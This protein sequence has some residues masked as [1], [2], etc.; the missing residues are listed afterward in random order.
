VTTERLYYLDS[1]LTDFTAKVV[2]SSADGRR[3]Y[4]DR[5]AF[6]PSSGG[7][8]YDLGRLGG[9]EI[10]EV[11]D[12]GDRIA[13]ITESAV[14]AGA[15]SG[16]IHWPRRYDHMQQ[17]TG[18]HLLSAVL[19]EM[20][21]F[22]TL[23]FHLGDEVSTIEISTKEITEKQIEEAE[24]HSNELAREGRPVRIAFEDAQDVKGLR[25]PSER[26][27]TLRI[28]EIEALEKSACGGTHVRSLAETLPV[29][30]RKIQKV[31]GNVRLEFVCGQRATRRA[32]QDFRVVQELSRQSA[33]PIDNLPEYLAAH[34]KRLGEAEQERQ[35]LSEGLAQREGR[36]AY[37]LTDPSGDG[38]RRAFWLVE[39]IDEIVRTKALAYVAG[40]KSL[41]LV[42]GAQPAGVLLACSSDSGIDAGA[43][44]KQTLARCGG[45]GGGSGTLAQGS[46]SA[47]SCVNELSKTLG[48]N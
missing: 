19:I 31:R 17:H 48:M 3:I 2:D 33:T 45:R 47:E 4:L 25:K 37:A 12:E 5:T 6:Y 27:G 8:P 40:A 44:L 36:Q 7:Q 43:I 22:Q 24:R 16:Q 11:A 18:Q 23:S 26:P 15:V 29:Q 32:K 28:I 30:I 14:L 35:L 38:I 1:Y 34:R 21:G 20:F 39:C 42:R 41:V 46:V 13:H 9:Q 10:V